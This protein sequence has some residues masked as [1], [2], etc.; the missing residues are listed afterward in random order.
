MILSEKG[1]KMTQQIIDILDEL[2]DDWRN[3]YNV[4]MLSTYINS[5]E[6]RIAELESDNKELSKDFTHSKYVDK[7]KE[8]EAPNTCEGCKWYVPE[9]T[10]HNYCDNVNSHICVR[11]SFN[12]VEDYYEPK[13]S[14]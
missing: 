13:D 14:K 3:E 2:D 7:Y 4:I 12:D 5:L 6:Q 9:D 10:Y 8:L 11:Y 1:N